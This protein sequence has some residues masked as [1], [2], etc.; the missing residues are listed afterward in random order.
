MW[1]KNRKR[2]STKRLPGPSLR[3]DP[4]AWAKLVF[5]RDRGETEIGGFGLSAPDDPLLI[6]DFLTVKQRCTWASVKFDDGAVADLF[7]ELVDQGLSPA[8]F[9]RIWLHT[10]PGDCPLPSVT[11][12]ATFARVFGRTDWSVMGIVAQ[13]D[14]TYARLSFHVG[15]CGAWEIPVGVDYGRPFAAADWEAWEEAYSANV[16]P[17]VRPMPL[18]S[19]LQEE[20]FIAWDLESEEEFYDGSAEFRSF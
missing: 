5:L 12:E 10:H 15:P 1:K 9:G 4:Y 19:A 17:D 2:R 7:D 11:D 18:A 16:V 3:F 6:V 20:E 8:R 14:A 13:N